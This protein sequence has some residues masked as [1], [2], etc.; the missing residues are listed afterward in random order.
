MSV[1]GAVAN[2]VKVGQ[3]YLGQWNS[4]VLSNAEAVPNNPSAA[5]L[6]R[7]Q[8]LIIKGNQELSYANDI[9][10]YILKNIRDLQP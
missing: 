3:A 9:L 2:G 6:Q 4:E 8:L 10:N 5:E 7:R 1:Y